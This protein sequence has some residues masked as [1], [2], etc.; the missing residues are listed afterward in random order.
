MYRIRN[1]LHATDFSESS[2]YAFQLA[3]SLA[4]DYG[5]RLT[6][7]HVFPPPP[8]M[9][10][11]EI[12]IA[13]PPQDTK[14]HLRELQLQLRNVQTEYHD[15]VLDRKLVEGDP[16]TEILAMADQVNAD[17][18]VLGTHGRTGLARLLMGSVAE[19]VS[20]KASTPVLL[21]K[22]PKVNSPQAKQAMNQAAVLEV[23]GTAI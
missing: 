1:I 11:G 21:A 18:I 8:V 7:L 19:V 4:H 13:V 16:A 14:E 15:L 17:L 2:G 22:A 10:A 23:A 12:P 3:A 20:R 5:A 9:V 6:L